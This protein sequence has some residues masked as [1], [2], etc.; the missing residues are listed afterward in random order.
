LTDRIYDTLFENKQNPQFPI[1]K[2]EDQFV[3]ADN[4]IIMIKINDEKFYIRVLRQV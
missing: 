1:D 4:N 3:S 2:I